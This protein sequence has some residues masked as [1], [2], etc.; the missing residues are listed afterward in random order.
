MYMIKDL[1]L[2]LNIEYLYSIPSKFHYT[3]W[4]K[5]YFSVFSYWHESNVI[6]S[7]SGDGK[8][9]YAP[10]WNTRQRSRR[11]GVL[12]KP[13]SENNTEHDFPATCHHRHN[14]KETSDWN[15]NLNKLN[16]F[17]ISLSILIS[18]PQ[19]NALFY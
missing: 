17:A 8:Y 9:C 15:L 14:I 11:N 18:L 19:M 16:I 3:M 10:L 5:Y 4:Y 6:T 13:S 2:G 7:C 12:S 1:R